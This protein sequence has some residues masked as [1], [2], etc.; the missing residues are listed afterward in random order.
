M[1]RQ[2]AS[3]LVEREEPAKRELRRLHCWVAIGYG[4]KSELH[5]YVVQGNSTGRMSLGSYR[6]QIP[7]P[8]IDEW[9]CI[10]DS[11]FVLEE[12]DDSWHCK[13][14]VNLVCAWKEDHGL[15]SFFNCSSSPSFSLI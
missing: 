11:K 4:F 6:D 13:N 10:A 15:E 1:G 5:W 2:Y 3:C 7:E 14:S 9:L 12:E 8:A